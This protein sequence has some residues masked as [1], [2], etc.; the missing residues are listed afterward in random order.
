MK[1]DEAIEIIPLD[2]DLSTPAS[3]PS[4]GRVVSITVV[5]VIATRNEEASIHKTVSDLRG[6]ADH[7]VVV[8]DSSEDDTLDE[9]KRAGAV[10]HAHPYR[11]G[12]DQCINDG[13]SIALGLGAGIIFTW[14]SGFEEEDIASLLSPIV[15]D[16]ADVV[17]GKRKR[18]YTWGEK[19]FSAYT[20]QYGISDPL[21][22]AKAYNSIVY[23]KVGY[24]DE[25]RGLGTHLLLE[26]AHRH[27]RIA[28]V[29]I[30][31]KP[32]SGYDRRGGHGSFAEN[33]HVLETLYRVMSKVKK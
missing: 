26:A 17:V 9:A 19:A 30:R 23:R 2:E 33:A 24:Y 32:R 27:Y 1:N 15:H 28:E 22:G 31:T 4:K 14:E 3:P 18:L 11:V 10:V 16:D 20:K 25:V 5:A 7:V 12:Y 8:D 6:H 13:F 29:P 21:S